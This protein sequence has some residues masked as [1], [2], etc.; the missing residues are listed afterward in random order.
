MFGGVND[1]TASVLLADA[2]GKPPPVAMNKN[3]LTDDC[4]LL[5]SE[6]NKNRDLREKKFYKF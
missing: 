2:D 4:Y 1:A 3:R 5:S 6:L